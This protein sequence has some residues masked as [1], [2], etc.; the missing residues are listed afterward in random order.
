MT[1]NFQ[2]AIPA[3][4]KFLAYESNVQFLLLF[5]TVIQCQ[6][7]RHCTELRTEFPVHLAH[8]QNEKNTIYKETVEWGRGIYAQL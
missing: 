2:P 3:L 8:G 4:K 1:V 6:C 5:L 7:T